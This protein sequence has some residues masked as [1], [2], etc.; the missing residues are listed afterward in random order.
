MPMAVCPEN[1]LVI[2]KEFSEDEIARLEPLLRNPAY[3]ALSGDVPRYRAAWLL[4]NLDRDKVFSY[5]WLLNQASWEADRDPVLKAR[6]KREFA[7]AVADLPQQPENGMWLSMQ[8][9]AVNAWRELGDLGR[10]QATLAALPLAS[11]KTEISAAEATE[12]DHQVA[13]ANRSLIAFANSISETIKR[14]D[15]S[16]EPLPLIPLRFA[17]EK[18]RALAKNSSDLIDEFCKTGAIRERIK[19]MGED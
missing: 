11:L 13:R 19:L 5:V 12:R 9:H 1:G 16:P 10:A 8:V 14:G 7:E 2:Y 17:A 3:Q 15:I 4:R 6:Y 18:C